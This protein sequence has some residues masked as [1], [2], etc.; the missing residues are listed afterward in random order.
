MT[1]CGLYEFQY[2]LHIIF[3]L[4]DKM[5]TFSEQF[6]TILL[7]NDKVAKIHLLQGWNII[8]PNKQCV[9]GH[10]MSLVNRQNG[11]GLRWMCTTQGCRETKGLRVGTIF[12][13]FTKTDIGR[14]SYAIYLWSEKVIGVR[15][16]EITGLSEKTVTKLRQLLRQCCSNHLARNP[17]RI[18]GGGGFNV[19]I[20]ESMF[21]HKQRAHVG[22]VARRE[23]WVFGL[24]DTH[25]V[26]ARPYLEIVPNRQ[27]VTL[28][29]IIN[30]HLTPGIA[31]IT[32]HS[33]QWAAY[34]NLP[35]FVPNCGTHNTVNH[36][37]NFVDPATGA[38][39][40]SIESCWN[41]VKYE[42]KKAKGCRREHLQ[43]HLD[44]FMWRD[45]YGG[46]DIFRSIVNCI[47][48]DYPQ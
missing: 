15:I 26:P 11:D 9:Q 38:H 30:Q 5:A 17:I 6:G 2:E 44:E 37:R 10:R 28:I 31:N 45:W 27:R 33:D 1:R 41:R 20:D 42:L 12:A 4:L 32:I 14:L 35:R 3:N 13:Q 19:E 18:N 40:Q 48:I 47:N 34:R 16:A 8:A 29:P 43:S 22:R 23:V 21:H 24:V 36:R 46:N 25:Y 39:T 7:G